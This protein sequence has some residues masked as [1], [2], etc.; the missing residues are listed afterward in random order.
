MYHPRVDTVPF[1]HPT[2]LFLSRTSV[3][4]AKPSLLTSGLDHRCLF[5]VLDSI[6]GRWAQ[7]YTLLQ[8]R[9]GIGSNYV[10]PMKSWIIIRSHR[11][12]TLLDPVI[13]DDWSLCPSIWICHF[14]WA[15]F[16]HDKLGG[17]HC[18]RFSAAHLEICHSVGS[19]S[20]EHFFNFFVWSFGYEFVNDLL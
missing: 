15:S 6:F 14:E 3:S 16:V 2:I 8:T 11:S 17:A 18:D 5:H 10:I 20:C 9:P 4:R 1:A 19:G 12:P 7:R 13:R